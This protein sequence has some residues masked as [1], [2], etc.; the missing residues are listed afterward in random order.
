MPED[1][2]F[3]LL[4]SISCLGK[5]I[6]RYLNTIIDGAIRLIKGVREFLGRVVSYVVRRSVE[7]IK[8]ISQVFWAA[9]SLFG[10]YTPGMAILFCGLEMDIVFLIVLGI[11]LTIALIFLTIN[12]ARRKDSD[13]NTPEAERNPESYFF[14]KIQG[15]AVVLSFIFLIILAMYLHT[16]APNSWL[17]IFIKKIGSSIIHFLF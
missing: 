13:I 4:D 8:E 11:V 9:C 10:L 17:L 15:V 1:L 5:R 6:Q 14:E 7:L 12:A 3:K 2:V 16:F